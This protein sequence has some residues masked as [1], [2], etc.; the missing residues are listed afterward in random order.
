ML[1]YADLYITYIQFMSLNDRVNRILARL[2]KLNAAITPVC[3]LPPITPVDPFQYDY[4][5]RVFK[6][7]PGHMLFSKDRGM[8]DMQE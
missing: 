1:V 2:D 8:C 7:Y 5:G 4:S 6:T 3:N